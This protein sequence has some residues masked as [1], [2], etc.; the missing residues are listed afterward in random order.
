M[1]NDDVQQKG[2]GLWS[3]PGWVIDTD[4][5]LREDV[6]FVSEGGF[7]RT[8]IRKEAS[9]SFTHAVLDTAFGGT[10]T[11]RRLDMTVVGAEA[12][13][14]DALGSSEKIEERHFYLPHCGPTGVTNVVGYNRIVYPNVY[15]L[16]DLWVFSG[17]LVQ[18]VM[19]VM[20]PGAD[21]KDI[22]LEFTGQN[23]LGVDLNGWLRILLA[24]EWI[25]LPQPV[26]YQFDSLNTIL[27]L[28]WTVEYEPQGNSGIVTL[29]YDAYDPA[30]PLVFLI[31]PPPMGGPSYEETGLC[32]STYIGGNGNDITN[33]VETDADGNVFITGNSKSDFLTFPAGPGLTYSISGN[34]VVFV[35]KF[36]ADYLPQWS[37]FLGGDVLSTSW[38]YSNAI[39]I[40]EVPNQRI[41]IGGQTTE[42]DFWT[43]DNDP[44][45]F[46]D[47][48]IGLFGM[49]FLAEFDED[50]LL[51]WSTYF[52]QDTEVNGMDIVP[53]TQHLAICGETQGLLPTVQYG[54][55]PN[56]M[57][58]PWAAGSEAFIALLDASDQLYMRTYYGGALD[59]KA[60]AIRA[61]GQK[62]V[63][64]GHTPNAGLALANPGGVAYCE[65]HHGGFDI[66]LIELS[67]SGVALWSTYLGG[68]L[69]EM[70]GRDGLS[71][72]PERDV[73]LTGSTTSPDLEIVNGPGWY[74][75]VY[76]ANPIQPENGLIAS[77]D[78]AD[79]SREWVTYWGKETHGTSILQEHTNDGLIRIAGISYFG[80]VPVTSFTG[81]YNQAELEETVHGSYFATFSDMHALEHVTLFGGGYSPP[82]TGIRAMV[83]YPAGT[84]AVG[85]H[86]KAFSPFGY[87]PLDDNQGTAWTD[88]LYNHLAESVVGSDGFL[89]LFCSELPT[90]IPWETP[91]GFTE[92]R[93]SYQDGLL[94]L[95]E[96]GLNGQGFSVYDAI[97]RNVISGNLQR[98]GERTSVRLPYVATGIYTV[99]LTDGRSAKF[100]V[101]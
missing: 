57:N 3:N 75:A 30:L 49:G 35:T 88:V 1:P 81:A 96:G 83:E 54:P 12:L 51:I 50:G 4:G 95:F 36:D 86:V 37:A 79:R 2:Y 20:W 84:F 23:D 28:L 82:Q 19:F 5:E 77:F 100:I 44:A 25:S 91:P 93:G 65:E 31:G 11:L 27:P 47:D 72:G 18:K 67:N 99:R 14:P 17:T 97:G 58:L 80:S 39:T 24:D 60:L 29:E 26:A 66:Y 74:D 10:D 63:V 90:G 42:Q 41:L 16:I 32:W 45:F 92:L 85:V 64:A 48:F 73:F 9:M 76:D 15:P 101:P 52:G 34:E 43:I 68:G 53:G 71:I 46:S 40:R 62:I 13:Y 59:E 94:T 56:S 21:P 22:E 33:D 69:D 89:T 98:Q 61:D 70:L 7:P 8:F 6:L 38:T 55:P 87:F 78:G